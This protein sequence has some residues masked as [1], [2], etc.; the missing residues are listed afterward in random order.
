MNIFDL[1]ED[2]E[3]KIEYL[4]DSPVFTIDN[5]YKYPEQVY[6]HIFVSPLKEGKV[7]LWKIEQKPSYNG[8]YFDDRRYSEFDERVMHIYFFLTKL[9]GDQPFRSLINTNVTFFNTDE[10]SLKFNNFNDNYWW[11]HKDE[12]YN[13]IV[14]FHDQWGTNL[15]SSELI[16]DYNEKE[17]IPINE[18]HEPWRLKEKYKLLKTLE[19]SYN[20]LVL[21]DGLKFIHGMDVTNDRYFGNESRNNQV[22]FFDS[23]DEQIG[24]FCV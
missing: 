12:G 8:I 15:Y 17:K 5:F 21:F 11:P 16:D 9:I 22:F 24:H 20:R 18:H 6:E 10:D 14:Y 13:G 1:N 2:N 3:V 23:V 4:E 19:P 7:G